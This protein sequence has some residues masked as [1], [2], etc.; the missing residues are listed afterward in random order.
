[1]DNTLPQVFMLLLDQWSSEVRTTCRGRERERVGEEGE[2]REAG[3][4][5]G[6]EKAELPKVELREEERQGLKGIVYGTK[7]GPFLLRMDCTNDKANRLRMA[8]FSFIS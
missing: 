7:G 5:R 8:S 4:G 1:M 3:R 2:L 6:G